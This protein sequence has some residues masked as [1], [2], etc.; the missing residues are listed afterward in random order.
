VIPELDEIRADAYLAHSF[1][2]SHSGK[3]CR[4]H[5]AICEGGWAQPA[6]RPA[7]LPHPISLSGPGT[8]PSA[9]DPVA[10]FEDWKALGIGGTRYFRPLVPQAQGFPCPTGKAGWLVKG[11]EGRGV[12]FWVG[13]G[14]GDG[15]GGM[16]KRYT[17][18]SWNRRL[19]IEVLE[20]REWPGFAKDY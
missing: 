5:F 15:A 18:W 1:D 10:G 16:V 4:F 6:L 11:R 9:G 8:R 12:G 13:R 14:G 19:V 2:L 20:G 7:G 17:R 3:T